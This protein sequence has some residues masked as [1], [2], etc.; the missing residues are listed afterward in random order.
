MAELGSGPT[1]RA[2]LVV[3]RRRKWWVISLAVLGLAASLALSL[4]EAKQYS[5]TAQLLVQSSGQGVDLGS[6]AQPVTTTDV[7][8]DLQLVTSA[9]VVKAVRAQLGAAPAVS[10]SEVAQTNV[11]ALTAVSS[12]PARAALVAN[13]YAR[14]FVAQTRSTAI[15]NLTAA[16]T[17]LQSQIGSLA[18]QIKAMQAKSGNAPEVA[19]LANQESVLKE[20]AAQLQV[21]GAVA[22]GAVELVTPAQPPASPSSPKPAQDA[23]LGLAAGLM[24]GLGAA[25]LRDSLDD[26]LTSKESAERLGRAPVLAMVPMV[27]SWKKRKDAVVAVSS[28]P[29]SPAAEAY[30]SLRTSL[31]FVRQA[32]ELR[33]L[34]VTSPAAAEGKTSVVANLGAVFARAGERVVLVSCDLRRPRL[35]EFFGLD[36]KSGLT[37]ILQGER[38]LEQQLQE[39]PGHDGLWILGAGRVPPNPAELLNGPKA[40]QVF[41]ALRE[42]FDLVLVDSPPVLPVTDAMVLSTYADGTLVVVAAG[43]TRQAAL[44]RTAERFAQAKAPVVG[45]VLNQVTK[46]NGYG[47]GYG[48]GSSY[49]SYQANPSLA[50]L[51]ASAN[52]HP[53]GPPAASE[54][55]SHRAT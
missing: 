17:Q 8:T 18:Q 25:F 13:T 37:A 4:R 20:E 28:D 23:L 35:G 33:T 51:P 2:Y 24:L 7:Q 42:K 53:D 10:T 38:T 52:G 5:A 32:H 31:Q 30:Q 46:E 39:V 49:G 41:A 6:A 15:S 19:A 34:L 22:T 54:K 16:Q 26:A 45:I 55:R 9:P 36:E 21:N 1:L 40:R 11:I 47:Y 48:Y 29:A 3:L 14:A 12:S 27:S 43:Q 44:Q 50:A